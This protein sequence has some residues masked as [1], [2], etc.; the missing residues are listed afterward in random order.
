MKINVNQNILKKLVNLSDKIFLKLHPAD[1]YNNYSEFID[2]D[3]IITNLDEALNGTICLARKST[4]LLE[5]AYRKGYPC[6][7][8][9]N[10]KDRVYVEHIFPSLSN[11]MIRSAYNLDDLKMFIN[12]I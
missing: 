7:I 3:R 4:V 11:S 12:S 5:S 2:K 9:F 10:Q 1:S 8:L 6:A